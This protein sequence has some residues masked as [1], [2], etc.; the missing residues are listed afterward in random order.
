MTGAC[1]RGIAEPSA[2]VL[3][4]T[5]KPDHEMPTNKTRRSVTN[6]GSNDRNIKTNTMV[7]FILDLVMHAGTL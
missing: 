1:R 3:E 4:K 5:G 6:G 7:G 2:K